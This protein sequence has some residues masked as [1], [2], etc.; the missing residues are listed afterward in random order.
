MNAFPRYRYAP[1]LGRVLIAL[2]FLFSGFEKLM[3]PAATLQYIA[4]AGIPLPQVAY[5]I[6]L[7]VELVGGL[8]LLLGFQARLAAL[9]LALFSL[10]AALRFHNN[11]ADQN[12]MLHFL[13]NLAIAGGLLQVFAFGPGAFALDRRR[14]E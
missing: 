4:S 13:K 12:Q 3:A 6:T 14:G 8:C 11:F 7:L 5:G 2:I 9:V 1:A 10:A